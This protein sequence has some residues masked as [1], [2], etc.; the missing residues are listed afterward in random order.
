MALMSTI[1]SR[2]IKH[3]HSL[4]PWSISFFSIHEWSKRWTPVRW[5]GEHNWSMDVYHRYCTNELMWVVN[6]L[7]HHWAAPCIDPHH[8][9]IILGCSKEIFHDFMATGISINFSPLGPTITSPHTG[10][11]SA[12]RAL[13]DLATDLQ[14]TMKQLLGEFDAD[15]SSMRQLHLPSFNVDQFHS[16]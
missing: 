12:Q 2:L 13:V 7:S 5:P 10:V 16:K 8:L 11:R 6:R 14:Q 1:G 9:L 15:I 3:H 4:V